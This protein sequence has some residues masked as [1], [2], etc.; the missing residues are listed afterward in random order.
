M[1]VLDGRGE[2]ARHLAGRVRGGRLEVLAAQQLPHSLG[3]MYEELTEHLG[4]LRARDEYKVM[5]LASYGKPRFVRELRRLVRADGRRRLPQPSGSTVGSR[6]PGPRTSD[7]TEEH[8]DLAASVQSGLEEVLL[9]LARWLHG[10]TGDRDADDGR[11]R[12]R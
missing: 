7:W 2:R 12:R 5:A 8:A 1:L 10:Q 6:R 4:F 3:L 11:R 9:D